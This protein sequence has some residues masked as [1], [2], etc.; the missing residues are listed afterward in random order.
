SLSQR[1]GHSGNRVLGHPAYPQPTRPRGTEP[2]GEAGGGPP[3]EG[4]SRQTRAV[5]SRLHSLK[6]NPGRGP[7]HPATTLVNVAALDGRG[8][9]PAPQRLGTRDA[10]ARECDIGQRV[11]E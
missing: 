7:K 6:S 5:W 1:G 2:A 11:R 3:A 9:L 4:T 10:V 8:L